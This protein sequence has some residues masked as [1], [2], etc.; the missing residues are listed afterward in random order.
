M[1]WQ[2]L[3]IYQ[4]SI[5]CAQLIIWIFHSQNPY[6]RHDKNSLISQ[7]MDKLNHSF[8]WKSIS[9]LNQAK[10]KIAR[11][12]LEALHSDKTAS[13]NIQR[14][15]AFT[16]RSRDNKKLEMK[17]NTIHP[18]FPSC[19][20]SDIQGIASTR[21]TIWQKSNALIKKTI[22]TETT[23][24]VKLAAKLLNVNRQQILC[25]LKLL[26]LSTWVM[27]HL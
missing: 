5:S 27:K 3:D 10:S 19:S 23:S 6:R 24:S 4:G 16:H 1:F 21:Q 25:S 2:L 26:I 8:N 15:N 14:Q 17:Q 12:F 18:P 22:M 7:H 13:I 9:I 20:H 11:E